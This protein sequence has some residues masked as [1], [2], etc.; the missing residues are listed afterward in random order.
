MRVLIAIVILILSMPEYPYAQSEV[1]VKKRAAN[2]IAEW[3]KWTRK[4]K[5]TEASLAISYNGKIVGKRGHGRTAHT[6]API[7]SLSKAITGICIAKLVEKGQLKFDQQL[8]EIVPS[9]NSKASIKSLLNQSSGY[10]K[11]ITQGNLDLFHNRGKENLDWVVQNELSSGA[12][13]EEGQSYNYN[14]ANYA[15]LGLAITTVT[16]LSYEKACNQLVLVPAGV[17][18]AKLNPEWRIMA[19]WGGW[20]MSAVDYLSFVNYYFNSKAKMGKSPT[21]FPHWK[22]S[23]GANYG[24]GY[25]FRKGRNG[26]YN[27]WHAGSWDYTA[28]GEHYRFAAFF[29]KWDNG[30]AISA[31]HNISALKSEHGELDQILSTAAHKP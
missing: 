27:F 22:F 18:N 6:A 12:K 29:A 17:R 20:K 11:D 16:G 23:G 19:S 1:L 9:L 10:K 3:G 7:A 14:N 30:W 2:M 28:Y 26:G 8:G 13:G 5:I 25:V 31:N 4:Y 24:M 15:M 21:S